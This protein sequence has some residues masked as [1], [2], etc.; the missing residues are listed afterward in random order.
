MATSPIDKIERSIENFVEGALSRLSGA[1]LSPSQAIAQLARALG[2]GVRYTEDG[3]PFAPDRFALT[4]HPSDA[5]VLLQSAPDLHEIL[6]EELL[7]VARDCG[8]MIFREPVVTVASDPT[9]GRQTIRVVAWHSTSP[10]ALTKA[11]ERTQEAEAQSIP[12]G[13]YLIVDGERHFPLSR[14]VINIGR[15]LDNHLIIDDQRISRT[16]A[17]IRIRAGRFEIF[18]LNSSAGTRVNGRMVSHHILQPGDV[19]ALADTRLVY[20]ED[21]GGPPDETPVY[22]PPFPPRPAGDQIT[23]IIDRNDQDDEEEEE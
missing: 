14:P 7:Q 12:R 18:D 3:K 13:A 2:D 17:Q 15:R 5:S 16:H 6:A 9:Q 22:A 11:M 23:H 1:S 20:G 4:L 10:L 19:I 21:P 8:Y